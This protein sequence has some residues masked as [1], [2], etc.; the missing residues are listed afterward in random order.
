M[1]GVRLYPACIT[2]IVPGPAKYETPSGQ[3]SGEM[4]LKRQYIIRQGEIEGM[5]DTGVTIGDEILQAVLGKQSDSQMKSIVATIQREQNQIIRNEQARL[6]L[7]R[8]R[9][10]AAKLQ[11]PCSGWRICFIAIAVH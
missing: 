3:I 6:L 1:T 11:P 10:E 4:T 9:R 5:F 8:E 2:I 7:V